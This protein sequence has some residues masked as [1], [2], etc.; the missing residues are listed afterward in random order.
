VTKMIPTMKL[1]V[2][3]LAAAAASLCCKVPAAHALAGSDAW[4]IVDNEGNNHCN[5]ATS[6][7]C[8]AAAAGSHGFCNEN[9]SGGSATPAAPQRAKRR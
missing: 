8:L 1:M 5:Y 9:S 2:L 6:Q 4:C 7:Q 3:A